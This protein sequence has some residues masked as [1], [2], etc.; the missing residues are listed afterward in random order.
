MIWRLRCS[1]T[2]AMTGSIEVATWMT[3]RT[4]W[5]EPWQPWQRSWFG[6]GW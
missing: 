5:S 2:S 3:A 4:L 6:I 1:R